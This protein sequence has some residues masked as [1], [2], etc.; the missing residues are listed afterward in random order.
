MGWP[1]WVGC[2]FSLLF[3]LGPWGL[4]GWVGPGCNRVRGARNDRSLRGSERISGGF[5]GQGTKGIRLK[6]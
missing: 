5:W 4:C 3:L 1:S 6:E 2:C